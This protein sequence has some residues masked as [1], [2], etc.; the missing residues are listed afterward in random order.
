MASGDATSAGAAGAASGGMETGGG[1]WFCTELA[2]ALN[3]KQSP[4]K[5]MRCSCG[6]VILRGTVFR[7]TDWTNTVLFSLAC[8]EQ[9][10]RKAALRWQRQHTPSTESGGC[11]SEHRSDCDQLSDLDD[12][13]SAM[14]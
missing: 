9:M 6:I 12:W 3:R 2:P 8:A 4:S 1:A 13:V 5:A 10:Y 14:S 7:F 11:P